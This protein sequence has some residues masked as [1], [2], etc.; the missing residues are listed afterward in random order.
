MSRFKPT[1]IKKQD[2]IMS[3]EERPHPILPGVKAMYVVVSTPEIT[4]DEKLPDDC[5]G[6]T[7]EEFDAKVPEIAE[8][9]AERFFTRAQEFEAQ[10]AKPKIILEP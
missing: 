4:V 2:P 6:W 9:L 5:F 8:R 1:V 10:Q 7:Q 3:L